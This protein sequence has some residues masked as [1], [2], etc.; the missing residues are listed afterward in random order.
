VEC[1]SLFRGKQI[2]EGRKCL[3]VRLR[4]RGTGVTLTHEQADAFQATILSR[5]KEQLRADLRA[6]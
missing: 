3:A 1:V 2:P 5:V 4:F 6:G